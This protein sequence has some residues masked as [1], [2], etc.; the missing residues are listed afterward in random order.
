M[1]EGPEVKNIVDILNSKLKGLSITRVIVLKCSRYF[2]KWEKVDVVEK[3]NVRE[4][5]DVGEKGN[6]SNPGDPV[7]HLSLP[8]L[9]V[10]IE[11]VFCKGKNIFFDFTQKD[12]PLSF[13]K[14]EKV[15]KPKTNRKINYGGVAHLKLI[16]S[17]VL[18]EYGKAVK[19]KGEKKSIVVMYNHLRMTGKWLMFPGKYT[20]IKFHLSNNKVLYYD[21]RRNFG[22]FEWLTEGQYF[23]KIQKIGVDIL[24]EPLTL[25][26]WNT[27]MK[28]KKI[29]KKQVCEVMMSQNYI[30]GIGNYLKSEILYKSRIKPD[31]L[32]SE[33]DDS[34]LSRLYED[35]KFIINHS[36][37]SGGLTFRD[38][39][40]PDGE[41]GRFEVLVY[42]KKDEKDRNGHLIKKDT[43]K[44][45]R[46]TFWVPEV[47]K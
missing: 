1:P 32:V 3:G 20:R 39:G 44:D 9:P 2:G 5:G 34:E 42:G 12:R 45:G 26:E 16:K 41:I 38:Y 47:Q 8:D 36:Y 11:R 40:G 17:G 30:S 4:K 21:D 25:T 28:N 27:I 7:D 10:T 18:D 31:R 29:S 6:R 13:N 15:T 43:F 46:T 33:L 35:C 37:K 23:M 22:A 19:E 14:I 24:S